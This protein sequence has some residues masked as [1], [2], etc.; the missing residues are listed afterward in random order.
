MP[1]L[2]RSDTARLARCQLEGSKMS[3]W[4]TTPAPGEDTIPPMPP[5]TARATWKDAGCIVPDSLG[6]YGQRAMIEYATDTWG[7]E[8]DPADV[9]LIA[10]ERDDKR[11]DTEYPPAGLTFEAWH[12]LCTDV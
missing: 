1:D 9:K 8:A 5:A 12:D 10:W 3:D 7:W 11:R 4:S 2:D 6:Q